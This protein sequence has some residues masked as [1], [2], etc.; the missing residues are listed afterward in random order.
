MPASSRK[1]AANIE[2]GTNRI[3]PVAIAA[4]LVAF[5]WPN[6]QSLFSAGSTTAPSH[7]SQIKAIDRPPGVESL[8][9]LPP[10][11]HDDAR[12]DSHPANDL[13]KFTHEDYLVRDSKSKKSAA[14]DQDGKQ[15]AAQH[16]IDP[17][18]SAPSSPRQP[19]AKAPKKISNGASRKTAA[20]AKQRL[21]SDHRHDDGG[22]DEQQDHDEEEESSS[23][24]LLDF[25]L[26]LLRGTLR[27]LYYLSL[28][29]VYLSRLLGSGAS[30]LYRAFRIGLSHS[31]RP[32]AVG[33]APLGYLVSGIVYL[34]YTAPMRVISAIAREVYPLYIFLGIASTVGV[35]MGVGAAL[36]LYITAFVFIDRTKVDPQQQQQQPQQPKKK[37]ADRKFKRSDTAGR[38]DGQDVDEGDASTEE[39]RQWRAMQAKAQS[40]ASAKGKG[41]ARARETSRGWSDEDGYG[42]D[43]HDGG[44]YGREAIYRSRRTGDTPPDLTPS[45]EDDDEFDNGY[46]YEGVADVSEQSWRRE[47]TSAA[48]SYRD[49]SGKLS[50]PIGATARTGW[51]HR[52]PRTGASPTTSPQHSFFGQPAVPSPVVVGSGRRADA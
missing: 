15:H 46:G 20:K 2:P 16:R 48:G 6:A 40:R 26:A 25:V 5:F 7:A 50:Y 38:S 31:L 42:E 24:L 45:T 28:P 51:A 11:Q 23:P 32:V 33:L 35:T 10:S 49:R 21:N 8:I 37:K 18:Q 30:R 41:K 19:R 52:T 13:F 1:A 27:G 12:L 14:Q 22:H 3:V 39:E 29:L 17:G 34:F 4:L 47:A 44:R 9:P 43:D 36:V